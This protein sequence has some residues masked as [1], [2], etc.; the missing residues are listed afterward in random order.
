M[1]TT[2]ELTI[3]DTLGNLDLFTTSNQGG[4]NETP[5]LDGDVIFG[6]GY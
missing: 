2:P 1:Y 5:P 4:P 3:L 6:N